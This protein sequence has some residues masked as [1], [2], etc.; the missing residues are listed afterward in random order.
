MSKFYPLEFTIDAD[1]DF[2]LRIQRDG[3]DYA[4]TQDAEVTI[5]ILDR[6]SAVLIEATEVA[7]HAQWSRAR[8]PIT[9]PKA[10]WTNVTEAQEVI[11]EVKIVDNGE[12]D[13][14]RKLCFANLSGIG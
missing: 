10:A 13:F 5:A 9:I 11:L 8:V 14:F 2:I 6:D 12:T 1:N 4:L 3:V 7:P